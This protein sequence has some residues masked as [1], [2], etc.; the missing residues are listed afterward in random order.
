V[1]AGFLFGI[2][3]RWLQTVFTARPAAAMLYGRNGHEIRE[4]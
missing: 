2:A 4:G 1:A 3:A